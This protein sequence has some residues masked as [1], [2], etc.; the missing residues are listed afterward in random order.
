MS[1]AKQAILVTRYI[2][3]YACGWRAY[4]SGLF[5]SSLLDKML[6]PRWSGKKG[7]DLNVDKEGGIL[8]WVTPFCQMDVTIT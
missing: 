3:C 6:G 2:H 8:N 7:L 1:C 5:D 4:I